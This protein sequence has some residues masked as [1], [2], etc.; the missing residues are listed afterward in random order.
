MKSSP[1][2]QL[3]LTFLAICGVAFPAQAKDGQTPLPPEQKYV[4]FRNPPRKYAT[5]HEGKWLVMVEKQLMSD[6]PALAKQALARLHRNLDEAMRIFPAPA[7]GRLEKVH[8]Y[9][10]YGPKAQNG[11]RDQG[12]DYIT[13]AEIESYHQLDPHWEDSII[14]YCAENYTQQ[15]DLWAL[16]ALVHEFSHAH[17]LEHWPEKQPDILGAWQHAMK[18]GLYH[19]VKDEQGKSIAKAYAATNQLEYFAELS[20]MYFARCDYY[21]F[22][23]KELKSYD[24]VGYAMIEKMWLNELDK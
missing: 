20:C 13:K 9:L 10:M 15:S 14:V 19:N 22:D 2:L 1:M 18:L 23:R 11:G 3:L 16:K 4:D 7:R 6:Q 5:T 8:I 17:Q 21:P 24:P 12:S